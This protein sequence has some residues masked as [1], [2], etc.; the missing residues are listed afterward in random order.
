MKQFVQTGAFQSGETQNFS[1]ASGKTYR[2][3]FSVSAQVTDLKRH[4]ARNSVRIFFWKRFI[5]TSPDHGGDNLRNACV[6][7]FVRA[8]IAAIANN[9]DAIGNGKHFLQTVGDINDRDATLAQSA[10]DLK[11]P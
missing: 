9:R 11:K 7:G 8:L 4:R 3:E 5:K 10:N 1:S 6:R 2:S